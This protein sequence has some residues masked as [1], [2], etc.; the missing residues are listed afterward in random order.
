MPS[1]H[2]EGLLTMRRGFC[3]GTLTIRRRRHARRLKLYTNIPRLHILLCDARRQFKLPYLI[4]QGNGVCWSF[5]PLYPRILNGI[6]YALE[7]IWNGVYQKGQGSFPVWGPTADG[8][9]DRV[10]PPAQNSG[11]HGYAIWDV[12]PIV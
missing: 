7:A 11:K 9:I 1:I 12:C 10:S 8:R 3:G 6:A 5:V 2:V 4:R